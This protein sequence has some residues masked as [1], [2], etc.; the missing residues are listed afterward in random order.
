M[1][2]RY[3]MAAGWAAL[4]FA[5]PANAQLKLSDFFL[6]LDPVTQSEDLYAENLG[7]E[8]MY[9]K[10]SVVEVTDPGLSTEGVHEIADPR[11]LGLL[12]SPQRLV[13]EPGGEKR[14][15]IL[16]LE[17]AMKDRFFKV[18]VTP[19]VGEI[20]SEQ[21][22]GVKLM[23]AYAAWVF[24]R[25]EGATPNLIGWREGNVLKVRNEGGTHAEL[26]GGKQCAPAAPGSCDTIDRVRILAGQ[27]KEIAL[28][29]PANPAP[30]AFKVLY[31]GKADPVS[32]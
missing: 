19:V 27:E 7:Q 31:A 29:Y 11:E 28:P 2:V 4:G 5:G 1:K 14:I 12:V 17:P 20:E 26:T 30:V 25:P 9:L 8:R 24:Q 32:F 3:L 10:V 16:A 15:R 13:V 18:T 6:D 23:I 22:I 21:M